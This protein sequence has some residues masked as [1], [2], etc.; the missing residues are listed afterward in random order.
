MK[1]PRWI[2]LGAIAAGTG[3]AHPPRPYTFDAATQAGADPVKVIATSL[4]RQGHPVV[5]VDRQKGEL[6]TDW[7]DTG[8]RFRETDD[9]EDTTNIFLRYHIQVSP[10][11]RQVTVSA[12]AQ[13]CVPYRPS[14]AEILATCIPMERI[15][16]TQQRSVERLG[17]TLA[18]S[19]G[20][21]G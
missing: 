18:A 14:R 13:R 4:A 9:Q 6:L 10:A 19:L 21:A 20:G 8:Y 17:Q 12:D 7:E 16:A 5:A 3:C 15:F 11:G 2:L 1:C